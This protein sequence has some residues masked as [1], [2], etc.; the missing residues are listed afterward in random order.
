MNISVQAAS[1]LV[2]LLLCSST[3]IWG[4]KPHR[5]A[6]YEDYIRR[7]YSE[8]MRQ[9]RQHRIPASIKM[10][11]GLLET[12]GGKS[13]LARDHHNHFGIKCHRSWQ[14]SRTYRTD[15]KPNECF[16]SY[17]SWQ[18]SYEDHSI[19]LKAPRYARL[20][21]LRPDDYH[22]WARGLQQAGYATDRGYANGL[23]KLIEDYELY[24]LDRGDLPQWL[25][26]KRSPQT[27]HKAKKDGQS[28]PT[29]FTRPSYLSYGLLYILAETGDSYERIAQ[30]L[31]TPPKRIARYNDAPVDYPLQQG[32][33][34]YLEGKHSRATKDYMT[35]LVVVGDSM[36]SIA[37]R[38]GIKLSSLYKLNDKD[39]DYIPIEGEILRLR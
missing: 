3:S 7:H 4:A 25:D 19:F 36:H 33:V 21:A 35:H 26:G 18:E 29:T 1:Y 13:P 22:G 28:S 27:A 17:R 9:M 32:D 39:E 2:A 30:E 11:Q 8:A 12:S 24:A 5:R 23:I 10:A 16:R 38:Y 31:G 14:G 15:D 6:T 34:V 20:F 37:Q